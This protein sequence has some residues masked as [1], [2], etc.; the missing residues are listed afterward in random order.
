MFL[1]VRQ[2]AGRY[3]ISAS[4]VWRWVGLGKLPEPVKINGSTRWRLRDL[5]QMEEKL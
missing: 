3:A 1:N 4:T 2:V 5:E